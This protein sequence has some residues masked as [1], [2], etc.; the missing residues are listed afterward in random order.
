MKGLEITAY[1]APASPPKKADAIKAL[2]PEAFSF[3]WRLDKRIHLV[4]ESAP[5]LTDD[6][7]VNIMDDDLF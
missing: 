6:D 4:D 5:E 2:G 7:L 1:L 3:R